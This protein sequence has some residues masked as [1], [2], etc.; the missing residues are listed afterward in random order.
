MKDRKIL[1]NSEITMSDDCFQNVCVDFLEYGNPIRS[2]TKFMYR[3][4]EGYLITALMSKN[5]KV[6][7][8]AQ[9]GAYKIP[10][11]TAVITKDEYQ[12]LCR[13]EMYDSKK[14]ASKKNV[15]R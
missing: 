12:K 3:K 14:T 5:S 6:V 9:G 7:I 13:R 8:L 11:L 1:V 4:E 10:H 2:N 15:K